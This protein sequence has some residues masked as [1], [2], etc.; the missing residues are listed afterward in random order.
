MD[1]VERARERREQER[2]R[3]KRERE[4]EERRERQREKERERECVCVREREMLKLL[5]GIKSATRLSS[6]TRDDRLGKPAQLSVSAQSALSQRQK[7]RSL[8]KNSYATFSH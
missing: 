3:E 7:I 4:R 6:K 2:E 1:Q 8:T 5:E